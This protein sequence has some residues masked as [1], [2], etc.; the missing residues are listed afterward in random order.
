MPNPAIQFN[1]PFNIALGDSAPSTLPPEVRGAIEALY[2]AVNQIQYVFHTHVGIGQQLQT[3]W[4]QLKYFHTLHLASPWR[5]YAEAT[6]TIVYGAAINLFLSGGAL[7]VRNA[8]ATNN[9][10]PAHGFCTTAAGLTNAVFGEVILMQGLLTGLAGLTIGTRYF[11]HTTDGQ[12]NATEPVAAGNIGQ[13]LGIA[14]DTTALLFC[15][16]FDFLQH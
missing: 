10:K 7:K 5:L 3:L 2:N 12:I 9:T 13:A 15:T 4:S 16:D 11:L 8:N 1:L 14:V 6:E